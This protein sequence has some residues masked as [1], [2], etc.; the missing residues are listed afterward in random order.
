ME[1]EVS[2]WQLKLFLRRLSRAPQQ[3]VSF[4]SNKT[5]CVSSGSSRL[6][7]NTYTILTGFKSTILVSMKE[8]LVV[9]R[10]RRQMQTNHRYDALTRHTKCLYQLYTQ[11][12]DIGFLLDLADHIHHD[13]GTSRTDKVPA[14]M[15]NTR[16]LGR[17]LNCLGRRLKLRSSNPFIIELRDACLRINVWLNRTDN[18]AS[19]YDEAL[20]KFLYNHIGWAIYQNI[21]SAKFVLVTAGLAE[22]KDF[23]S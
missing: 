9:M 10:E 2:L 14:Y 23:E 16:L 7:F 5:K 6:P 4:K 19:T 12:Q 20:L 18:A 13:I 8:R 21:Q 15:N 17:V 1:P 3:P 11:V 22:P